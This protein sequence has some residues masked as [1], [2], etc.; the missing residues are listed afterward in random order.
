M[1]YT[2]NATRGALRD[3]VEEH[4]GSSV[5]LSLSQNR[6]GLGARVGAREGDSLE[7]VMSFGKKYGT[8]SA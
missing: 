3:A 7:P 4:T 2:E 1:F 5:N 6:L 8:L